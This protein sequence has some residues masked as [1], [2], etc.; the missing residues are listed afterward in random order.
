MWQSTLY[1]VCGQ[2]IKKS[3]GQGEE[4][5]SSQFFFWEHELSFSLF[6]LLFDLSVERLISQN[7]VRMAALFYCEEETDVSHLFNQGLTYLN[8][9]KMGESQI[10]TCIFCVALKQ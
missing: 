2:N 7:Q 10:S 9:K 5:L 4:E 1:Q 6:K 8:L 3:L